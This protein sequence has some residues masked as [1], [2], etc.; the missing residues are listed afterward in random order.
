MLLRSGRSSNRLIE[1]EAKITKLTS[2]PNSLFIHIVGST[3]AN[4]PNEA[5]AATR[6]IARERL[7][8]GATLPA[9]LT[10]VAIPAPPSPNPIRVVAENNTNSEVG[11]LIRKMP[12]E[13]E[14]I[15]N[16]RTF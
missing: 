16:A 15:P 1:I 5:A 13:Y 4:C 3:T 14:I 8:T 2:Q 6:P 7:L 10:M 11:L 9:I 12:D